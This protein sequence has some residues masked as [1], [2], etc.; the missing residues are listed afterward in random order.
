MVL[1]SIRSA[2]SSL[3]LL[4]CE[5]CATTLRLQMMPSRPSL[6]STMRS[7][8]AAACVLPLQEIRFQ[9]PLLGAPRHTVVRVLHSAA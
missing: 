9:P 5:V 7:P 2:C 6:F 4:F 1:D 3:N 8:V